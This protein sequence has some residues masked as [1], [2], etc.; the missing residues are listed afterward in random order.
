[1]HFYTRL[2]WMV[3]DTFA[4]SGELTRDLENNRTSQWRLGAT[5]QH[6]PRFSTFADYDDLPIYD[7]RLLTYGFNYQL[8]TKYRVGFSQR[9]DLEDGSTRDINLNL[10]RRLPRWRFLVVAS[11]DDIDD[12]TT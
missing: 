11:V 12:E 6:T 4:L 8:T 5:M 9:L 3:T 1:D 10:E 7:S 2:L